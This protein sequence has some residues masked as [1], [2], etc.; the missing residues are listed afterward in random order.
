MRIASTQLKPEA[1]RP[2]S[3]KGA[4]SEEMGP[5]PVVPAKVQ[6]LP[7]QAYLKTINT[8]VIFTEYGIHDRQK[9]KKD[10]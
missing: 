9:S 5:V 4:R 2:S 7:R 3:G 6:T 1:M 10:H 8:S